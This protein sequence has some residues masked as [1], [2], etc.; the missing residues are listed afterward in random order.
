MS[1]SEFVRACDAEQAVNVTHVICASQD[2]VLASYVR[3]PYRMDTLRLFFSMTKSFASLAVGIACDMRLVGLDERLVDIFRDECP[4]DPHENLQKITIRHL[5]TM[6]GGIHENTYSA[7]F[8]QSDWV[9]AY[10]SQEFPHEPGSFYRY[11]THGSHMLSALITK[12]TGISMEAFLN[13]HLLHPMGIDEAQ[14]EHSPE[15][16]TAGGMGLSLYPASLVKIAQ[17]LLNRGVYQGWRY[18]SEEYLEMATQ[19]QIVKRD[20]FGKA[21]CEYG[22]WEYGFQFHIGKG[23]YYRMDG[24]FGQVCL[25]CPDRNRAF[26]ALSSGSKTEKLLKLMYEHLLDGEMDICK[27]Q[28]GDR[29][30]PTAPVPCGRYR[31]EANE[32]RIR[33]IEIREPETG[34]FRMRVFRE[35]NEEQIDFSLRYD[36]GG[37]MRFVKDLEEHE[38][39]YVCRAEFCDAL[40]LTL[41]Y[42][43]TPYITKY[44]FIFE[45]ERILFE[46]SINQSFTLKSISAQG[47]KIS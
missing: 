16:L 23:G 19:P 32:G 34:K 13:S 9:R 37:Q 22:G 14:W 43:E 2:Q 18:V 10:L 47:R 27:A 38:Q 33:E 11:S 39:E 12:K 36:V 4:A 7:L 1:F 41:Y 21:E 6:S 46:W 28:T 17:M 25:V 30:C 42:I 3:E 44:R 31:M 26:I 24:A 15:G 40:E 29:I 20:D 5:L 8:P 35:E 45:E